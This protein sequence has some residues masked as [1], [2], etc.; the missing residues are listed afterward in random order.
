VVSYRNR[1]LALKT[2]LR[3]LR[4]MRFLFK[5][6][7]IFAIFLNF[8]PRLRRL[9]SSSTAYM[10]LKVNEREHFCP[11]C[12]PL[13]AFPLTGLAY[14]QQ[15]KVTFALILFQP[16]RANWTLTSAFPFS[17]TILRKWQRFHEILHIIRHSFIELLTLS[18]S[19]CV[20][21]NAYIECF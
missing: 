1:E 20:F 3:C 19:C 8:G 12:L 2:K 13:S 21:Y 10:K 7:E 11:G 5:I 16:P 14:S 15:E 18:N 9:P 17:F 6:S 4:I